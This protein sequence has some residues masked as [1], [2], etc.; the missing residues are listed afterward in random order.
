MNKPFLFAVDGDVAGTATQRTDDCVS[1]N[2]L[3]FLELLQLTTTQHHVDTRATQM[4]H[5]SVKP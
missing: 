1:D 2:C 3:S 5:C 4:A